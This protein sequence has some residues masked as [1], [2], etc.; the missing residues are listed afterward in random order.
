M[1]HPIYACAHL[2]GRVSS[3]HV[4]YIDTLL[5]TLCLDAFY[6][7]LNVKIR[8]T[9]IPTRLEKLRASNFHDLSKG[10]KKCLVPRGAVGYIENERNMSTNRGRIRQKRDAG[11]SLQGIQREV[12]FFSLEAEFHD[13][14]CLGEVSSKKFS[15][16]STF[17]KKK[18]KVDVREKERFEMWHQDVDNSSKKI[19]LYSRH[20]NVVCPI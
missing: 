6:I 9:G 15:Y 1:V 13:Q 7:Y 4:F 17:K 11:S 12:N 18:I 8:R 14:M 5:W 2:D 16:I 19:L 3:E 20:L 10:S